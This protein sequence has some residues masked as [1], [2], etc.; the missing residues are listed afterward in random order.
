[1]SDDDPGNQTDSDEAR[2]HPMTPN[3]TTRQRRTREREEEVMMNGGLPQ[4]K[5]RE[6]LTDWK[7]VRGRNHIISHFHIIDN[8]SSKQVYPN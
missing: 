3:G 5:V 1:M 7:V 6:R 2:T 8:I 4:K